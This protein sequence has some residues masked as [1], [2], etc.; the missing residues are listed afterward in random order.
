MGT[1]GNIWGNLGASVGHLGA[2]G[3]IWA[4][5]GSPRGTQRH[6]K[7]S[8]GYPQAPLKA[9]KCHQNGWSGLASPGIGRLSLGIPRLKPIKPRLERVNVGIPRLVPTK[10]R[11]LLQLSLGTPR[12]SQPACAWAGEALGSQ[13]S[14]VAAPALLGSQ[15]TALLSRHRAQARSGNPPAGALKEPSYSLRAKTNDKSHRATLSP[16][17]WRG[18]SLPGHRQEACYKWLLP[19]SRTR[20]STPP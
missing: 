5:K 13:G 17:W 15:G 7:G 14:A 16:L 4:P 20:L 18:L 3:D 10:H 1:S 19:L 2:S 6:P 11:T 9:L 12:L 8:Q